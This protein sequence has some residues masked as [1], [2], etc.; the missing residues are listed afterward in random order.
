MYLSIPTHDLAWLVQTASR[1]IPARSTLPAIQGCLIEALS[2]RVVLS[3]TNL[4]WGVRAS[5]PAK[6]SSSGSLVVSAK[7]LSDV[8]R[9]LPPGEVTLSLDES[10]WA[11]IVKAGSSQMVLNAVPADDFP[12]WPEPAGGH[13][14]SLAAS[15]FRELVRIGATC[16]VSNPARPLWGACLIDLLGGELVMVSTDQ[17]ALSRAKASMETAEAR[18]I[19]PANVLQDLARLNLK[20]K[21]TEDD[22]EQVSLELCDGYLYFTSNNISCFTRLIEGQYYAYEQVIPK[23]FSSTA[24]VSTEAMAGAASRASIVASEEDRAMRIILDNKSQTLTIRA[25]S[26]EKGKMEEALPAQVEGEDIEIWVQ[27]R[28]VL[29]ALSKIDSE[30]TMFGMTGQVSQMVIEPVHDEPAGGA[31]KSTFVIMPMSPKGA[32]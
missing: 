32:F 11:L 31:V 22:E 25:G 8:V 14:I 17:F 30:D 4:D 20:D 3:G 9:T 28:Y 16:A 15:T 23:T 19:V 27:H 13:K 26:A 5:L 7:I 10:A 2:D 18:A 6:V 24:K 29:Q 12:K 21:D 1:P